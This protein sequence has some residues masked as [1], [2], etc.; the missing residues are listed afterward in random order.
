MIP[1]Q[2]DLIAVL[3]LGVV[4][5]TLGGMIGFGSSIMLM[6]ALVFMYGPREAVPVMA[7]AALLAN[8]SRVGIWWREIN[9]PAFVAYSLTGVPAAALGAMTLLTIP[10][11]GVETA[12]GVFFLAVIPVRRWLVAHDLRIRLW[13]LAIAG[14]VVGYITGIVVSTGPINAPFFLALGL[15]KGAYIGTEAASSLALYLA[16]SIVFR[17]FGA[18]PIDIIAKG[19]VIG[20]SLMVGAFVARRLLLKMS[21]AQFNLLIEGLLLL[22]GVTMLGAA[23]RG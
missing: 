11:R 14:A 1:L 15:V 4:A 20:S 13:Q 22:S 19:L 21:A 5:G 6:P 7:V 8:A 3:L 18:L 9:W 23:L 2:L 12:M 16:K 10:Q 17:S